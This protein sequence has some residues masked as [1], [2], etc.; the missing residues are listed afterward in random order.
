[1]TAQA[2]L[3]RVVGRT[4]CSAD[5]TPQHSR[6]TGPCAT[7]TCRAPVLP[8]EFPPLITVP[9]LAQQPSRCSA[10]LRQLPRCAPV[11]VPLAADGCARRGKSIG[12]GGGAEGAA[13]PALHLRSLATSPDSPTA[14]GHDHIS[15]SSIGAAQAQR[16]PP[17]ACSSGGSGCVAS[18]SVG[19][20]PNQLRTVLVCCCRWH[21][22]PST[23]AAPPRLR[24]MRLVGWQLAAEM[25]CR[26][27]VRTPL[28]CTHGLNNCSAFLYCCSTASTCT[29]SG[30]SFTTPLLPAGS[31]GAPGMLPA[32]ALCCCRLR[33]CCYRRA[34]WLTAHRP[35]SCSPHCLQT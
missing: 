18:S 6:D 4:G 21:A 20:P 19:L 15:S 28:E 23:L 9:V 11:K 2:P 32:W 12:G 14:C 27:T 10:S 30:V 34:V 26:L 35:P 22:A 29:S 33:C 25:F 1:M 5:L 24:T 16:R 13:G 3:A 17:G 8:V 31:P 7:L